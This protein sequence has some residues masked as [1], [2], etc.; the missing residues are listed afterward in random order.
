MYKN[1]VEELILCFK[2]VDMWEDV[3]RKKMRERMLDNKKN[4]PKQNSDS[5]FLYSSVILMAHKRQ[6]CKE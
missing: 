5:W 3:Y 4:S 2:L 1:E 6:P